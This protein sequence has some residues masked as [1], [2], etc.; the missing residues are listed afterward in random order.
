LYSPPYRGRARP[1]WRSPTPCRASGAAASSPSAYGCTHSRTSDWLHGPHTGC[2]QLNRVLTHNNNLKSASPTSA[3]CAPCGPPS[4]L[5]SRLW[6]QRRGQTW[7]GRRDVAVQVDPRKTRNDLVETR[8]SDQICRLTGCETGR[9][10]VMGHLDATCTGPPP[11]LPGGGGGGVGGPFPPGGGGG[12]GGAPG[13][14]PPGGGGGG[15][16][17]PGSLPPGGDSGG[18]GGAAPGN[19]PPGG[20]GGGG[21]GGAPGSLPP[22]GGGGG[23]GARKP[24]GGGGGGLPSPPGGGGGGGGG[25]GAPGPDSLPPGGGGGGGGTPTLS[26]PGGGGGGGGGGGAPPPA[27]AP[28]P[29]PAPA[30]EAPGSSWLSIFLTFSLPNFSRRSRRLAFTSA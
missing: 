1:P 14:L 3:P 27:P 13:S 7:A 20:G 22:G 24:P 17:A 30:L 21:G 26:S 8:V 4:G 10:N 29:A 12:G 23:G 18:G 15:G 28:T 5:A 2:H 19:L 9:F 6:R 11:S 25:G 16:G